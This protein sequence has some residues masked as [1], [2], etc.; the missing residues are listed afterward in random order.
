VGEGAKS[1]PVSTPLGGGV[2]CGVTLEYRGYSPGDVP[3][4][5]RYAVISLTCAL[6]AC[7]GLPLLVK[8]LRWRWIDPQRSDIASVLLIWFLAC[9]V[10]CGRASWLETHAADQ[11]RR[12]RALAALALTLNIL[13]LLASAIGLLV[14]AWIERHG[15]R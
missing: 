12:G 6:L 10:V 3:R 7:P 13:W 11:P 2:T 1:D 8:F 15:L 9:G 4:V 5:S 14:I